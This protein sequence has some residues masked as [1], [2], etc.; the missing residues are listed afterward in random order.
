MFNWESQGAW[1]LFFLFSSLEKSQGF[2]YFSSIPSGTFNQ[3]HCTIAFATWSDF[4][5]GICFFETCYSSNE[6]GY[7]SE[8]VCCFYREVGPTV[9][10]F[11]L[12]PVFGW[13]LYHKMKKWETTWVPCLSTTGYFFHYFFHSLF[14]CRWNRPVMLSFASSNPTLVVFLSWI[15]QTLYATVSEAIYRQ[16]WCFSFHAKAF[17]RNLLKRSCFGI[18][19]NNIILNNL[20]MLTTKVTKHKC[21][22]IRCSF[23][24]SW[25]GLCLWIKWIISFNID[26]LVMGRNIIYSKCLRAI[27]TG[28]YALQTQWRYLGSRD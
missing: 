1:F 14:T 3:E 12:S 19:E 4:L 13:C 27:S 8:L 2:P 22:S 9:F 21:L 23:C 16:P 15:L 25:E 11:L 5:Y 10:L 7:M 18:V 28:C 20:F 26:P 17:L 24:S 6:P